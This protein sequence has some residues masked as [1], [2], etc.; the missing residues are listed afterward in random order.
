MYNTSVAGQDRFMLEYGNAAHYVIL[1]I[2]GLHRVWFG[3]RHVKL[4]RLF[5]SLRFCRQNVGIA[6]DDASQDRNGIQSNID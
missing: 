3:G 2:A 4:A 5:V 6:E 1:G